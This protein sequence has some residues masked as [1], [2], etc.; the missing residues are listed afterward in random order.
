MEEH[1]QLEI[2][3]YANIIGHNI[4]KEWCP[5]TWSAFENYTLEST[6]LSR[7]EAF[8]LGAGLDPN[9]PIWPDPTTYMIE[10]SFVVLKTHD[11]PKRSRIVFT[12][13]GKDFLEKYK[14]LTRTDFPW[15]PD[16]AV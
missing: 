10:C 4:V 9:D 3:E 7:D 13:E 16:K 6:S 2:R 15:T 12:R 8:M 11:D 1:A 14:N 5:Q